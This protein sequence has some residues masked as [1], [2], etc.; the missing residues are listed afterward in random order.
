MYVKMHISCTKS[1]NIPISI[2]FATLAHMINVYEI[3]LN[4]TNYPIF[5]MQGFIYCLWTFI[6]KLFWSA[7]IATMKGLGI[8]LKIYVKGELVPCLNDIVHLGHVIKNDRSDTL[9]KSGV[10]DFN[11][12]SIV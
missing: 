5:N 1:L 10:R 12:K 11:S 4:T 3:C 6:L 2:A 9:I 7:G 8:I